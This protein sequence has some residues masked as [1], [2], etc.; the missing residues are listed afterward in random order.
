MKK[1]KTGSGTLDFAPGCVYRDVKPTDQSLA[2]S[3]KAGKR[4]AYQAAMTRYGPL[5]VS[6]AASMVSDRRD[7]EEILQDTFVNLF[8]S[9]DRYDPR[10]ASLATWVGRIAFNRAVDFVR[11]QHPEELTDDS[12]ALADMADIS[13]TDPALESDITLLKEAILTLRA[14]ERTLLSL[15]YFDNMP[16][17][18][19]AFI[20]KSNPAALSA[21]LYRLRHKLS[22]IIHEKRKQL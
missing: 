6:I 5:V 18:D 22:L 11:R 13:D 9:I 14:P 3:L 7:V 1:E 8:R 20:L 15:V 4:S 2:D 17:S 12:E 10:E 16:L 19:A 21:R